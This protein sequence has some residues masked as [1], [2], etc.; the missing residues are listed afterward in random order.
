MSSL[1]PWKN[2]GISLGMRCVLLAKDEMTKGVASLQPSPGPNTSPRIAEYFAG[3]VRDLNGDG[4]IGPT[5]FLRIKEGNWCAAFVSWCLEQCILEGEVRPH[6]YRAGVV[7][8]VSDAKAKGLWH[9]Y[10]EVLQHKW[11]P[12]TGDLAIWDR[13]TPGKPETAW[14][15]HVNRV[16]GWGGLDENA[17]TPRLT[18]IG[19]N[20]SRMIRL[21]DQ[22]PKKLVATKLLGFITYRQTA[23]P[24]NREHD[25]ELVREFQT[26]MKEAP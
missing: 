12:R 16:V 22:P 24:Q 15:R 20:E 19:G 11:E 23:E 6:Y 26:A 7:E 14:F 3:C 9:S 5:E 4:R 18:T 13:S 10:S 2:P 1:P 8:L 25:L 21:V 17:L